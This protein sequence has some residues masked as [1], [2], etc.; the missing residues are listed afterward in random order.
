MKYNLSQ[1]GRK[2]TSPSGILSL[3]ED[4]GQ[5]MQTDEKIY[6]LGGGNPA[7]IPEVNRIWR[8]RMSAILENGGEY[9]RMVA[10]YDTP[11]GKESFL[12]ALAEMLRREYGWDVG[13]ENIAVTNGSQTAFFL[14]LNL[15]SGTDA[16]GRKRKILFPLLPEYIGYADQSIEPGSFVARKPRIEEFENR[17]FKY[18][19]DVEHLEVGED[20]GAIC[21]SRPTNPTGNVITDAELEQLSALAKRKGI[22][23]LVDNAYGEPFPS[24]IF[25]EAKLMWDEHII[26][27]MSLSKIGLPAVRTGIIVASKE[28][29]RALSSV[30]A[31]F[32]LAN[33]S[34]GQV[35]TAP[36]I[37]DGS[38]LSLSREVI[39]PYYRRKALATMGWMDE[40]FEGLPYMIHKAEGA[41]FLWLWFKDLPISSIELYERLKRR[42]VLVIPGSYFFFGNDEP[43]PHRDQCLRI[44]YAQ[45]EG[46]VRRGIEIMAE[47]LKKVYGV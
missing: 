10:N 11:R 17:R 34:L 3:M 20:I 26:L 37:N 47:E 13:P 40:L 42:N 16:G 23:L 43:W 45:D 30:N 33:A 22:P 24:I 27:G 31:I 21:V 32:S 5:A 2:F 4:L 12:N 19:V 1:F 6:M 44:S 15:F 8:E 9:E 7:H 18:H 36:L 28:V 35:L 14:L 46:D 39:K 25:D 38:L 29:I 41:I